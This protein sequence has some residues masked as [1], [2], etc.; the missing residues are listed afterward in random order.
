MLNISNVKVVGFDEAIR[1]MRNSRNSWEKSDSKTYE[2]GEKDL[3]LMQ[4]LANEG[5]SSAKYRRI[6][7]VY[8]DIKASLYW[9]K[10]FDTYKVGTVSL[11][12]STMHTIAQEP[13]TRADFSTE[14]L[15]NEL[16]NIPF[17]HSSHV[18]F[19][20]LD[21]LDLVIKTLNTF[22]QKY[23]ETNNPI[24]WKQIIQLL[25]SSYLQKRT[26]ILNYEVLANIYR[27]RRNHKLFEWR[28]FCDWIIDLPYSDIIT[29]NIS[30]R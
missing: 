20:A 5:P 21:I 7:S 18:P 6:I 2:I 25:P 1:G 17:A 10:Q 14:F 9:W 12:C 22:R 8:A 13:L 16:Y 27:D 15:T 24:Y 11:S 26:V 19:S 28:E 3:S 30:S 29:T 23:I 4:T